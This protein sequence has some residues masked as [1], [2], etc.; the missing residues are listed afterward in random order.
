MYTYMFNM[1]ILLNYCT[2]AKKNYR[3]CGKK[4]ILKIG[5]NEPKR[6]SPDTVFQETSVL[7]Y[8]NFLLKPF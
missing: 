2:N 1:T 8:A 7:Q 4:T 6:Y 3:H 5:H